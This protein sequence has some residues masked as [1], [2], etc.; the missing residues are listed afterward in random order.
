MTLLMFVNVA[1]SFKY[2]VEQQPIGHELFREF[3]GTKPEL[4]KAIDFLDVVVSSLMAA[5]QIFIIK[6]HFYVKM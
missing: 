1:L 3:C 5:A 4:K 2:I 6:M